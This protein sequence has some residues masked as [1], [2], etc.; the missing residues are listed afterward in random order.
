MDATSNF[1]FSFA[2]GSESLT[3]VDPSAHDPVPERVHF[4]QSDISRTISVVYRCERTEDLL[5]QPALTLFRQQWHFIVSSSTT[6][7][8]FIEE[9][10]QLFMALFWSHSA[11]GYSGPG[12]REVCGRRMCRIV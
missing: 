10:Q 7:I 6:T 5:G 2:K 1:S 4:L 3:T 9:N 12:R 8:S 11:R